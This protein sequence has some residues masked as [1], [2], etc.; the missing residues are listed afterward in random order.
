MIA[1]GSKIIN[2]FFYPIFSKGE[3]TYAD[4]RK[5]KYL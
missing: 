5:E 3:G 1:T 2:Y 4:V